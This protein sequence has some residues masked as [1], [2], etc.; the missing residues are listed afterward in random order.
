[1]NIKKNFFVT[2]ATAFLGFAALTVPVTFA[3]ADTLTV[4]PS[5][6]GT[7]DLIGATNAQWTFT[8]TT[9]GA[10]SRGNVIQFTLP[11]VVQAQPFG[12]GTPLLIATT[13][14]SLYPSAIPT[15][16]IPGVSVA[17]TPGGP[18]IYGFATSTVPA[19]TTF[20]VTLGGI[21]GATGQLS[22]M[23]NLAWNV[24][25]GTTA[26]PT[27]P[28]G[29]LSQTAFIATSTK[30]LIRAGGAL[31]SDVNSRITATS[32]NVSA[33]NVSYTFSIK[34]TTT[35]PI[36]GKIMVNF[37][38]TYDLSGATTTSTQTV[39]TSGAQVAM[40]AIATSTGTGTNRVILTTSAAAVTAGN[41]ITV[42]VNGLTNPATAGV[43][44][45]F[46]IF[47]AKAN[48]GL[49]D[50]SYF[51]FE[52][53]DYGSGAPPPSDTV[54][55]GG[56]NT[57]VVQV[58]KANGSGGTTAL[59]AGDIAQ[60]KVGVGCPD[61]GYFMGTQWLNSSGVATY[62][63]I[64]D[65]NYMTGVDPFSK[66]DSSFYSTFLPPGM[67]MVNVVSSGGVGQTSTT[68]LVFGVPN[69]TTT[70]VLT[71]GVSGKNAFINAYSADNQSFANVYQTTGYSTLGFDGSGNGYAQIPINS[72]E[73][74]N[75]SVVGGTFGSGA[76]FTSGGIE[77]WAP[78]IPSIRLTGASTTPVNL[79]S[80]AY[81]SASNTLNVSLVDTSSAPITNAC[82]GVS[83]SGGGV[84]MNQQ[85]VVCSPN[86]GN[87]YQF[88]VPS[89]TI[90]INV[91]RNGF[92]V[93]AQYPVAISSA[94]TNKTITLAAPTSFIN[95]T[96]QTS[97]GTAIN[98]APVFANGSS[99]FGNAMTGSSGTTKIYVQPGTYSVQGFAP[100]F[101]QLTA[102][103]VTVTNSSN[104]SA[105][106]TVNTGTLKTISGTVTQG[107][108]GVAGINVGAHGTGT[109]SGGNNTQTDASGNYTLYV[110]TGTYQ[111]EGWSQGV[112]GLSPQA[113]DVTSGNAANVNWSLGAQG[114]L[115][116]TI[117]NASTISPL[118][119]G[120]SD[121][122]TGKGNGTNTWTTSGTSE[123]A[124]VALPA[125]TYNVQ[126]GSPSLGQF[127]SQIGVAITG[128][129]TTNV[130][131]NAQASSTLVTLSGTTGVA[132]TNVWASRTNGQGFFSTQT[133]ASGNYTLHV[134]DATT[135]RVGVR[136]LAYIATQGDIGVTVS[137]NTT[138]N[139]TL[140]AAG[141]TITGKVFDSNGNGIASGWVT[142]IKTGAASST[143]IGAPTDAG[144]NYT[145]NVDSG[146]VW[147]VTAQGPCYLP[148]SAVAA[149]A[150]DTGKNITLVAQGGCSA[151]TPDVSAITD[152][153]GGQISKSDMTLNIPASALGTSQNSVNVSVTS[154]ATVVS[155]ANATPLAGSVK[156]ITA[157]NSSGQSITS[158]NNDASLSITYDPSQL[159]VGFTE[160]KLQLGYFDNTTGQWE[161]VA[162]TIDTTNHVL[163]AQVS[164]FTE[165]GPILPG[166]PSAPTGLSASAASASQINLSWT[167][168]P[169]ATSYTIYRS[170]TNSGF[171]NSIATGVT[172]ASYSDAGL[173]AST[174]YYYEVAG[175]NSSGEG[176][177]SSAANATTN[178][179]PAVA[180]S[181]GG[182]GPP[183]GFLSTPFLPTAIVSALGKNATSTARSFEIAVASSTPGSIVQTEK[184]SPGVSA[185]FTLTLSFGSR[186]S[187]VLR[188][189]KILGV[190][191]TGYFGHM[192]RRAVEA[193]QIKYGVVSSGAST[194]NG[195]GLFGPKT[196][197][198]IEDIFGVA[199]AGTQP[200][201]AEAHP[202]IQVVFSR[203]LKLGVSGSDVRILQTVLNSDSDTQV[204]I[205][206]DGS[207]GHETGYFGSLTAH[208]V[209]KFQLKHGVVSAGSS[210]L[211]FVGPMTR[212]KL[213]TLRSQ[214]KR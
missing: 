54:Y 28:G 115:H 13:S 181:G 38:S 66:G 134:P 7:D 187:D 202:V 12:V 23:S 177:N 16:T 86:S 108:V 164:H 118:F 179:T 3:F 89:G 30:S 98:G 189:Q 110:P 55:I 11:S 21:N 127:G 213:E 71:G 57:L 185:Y 6:A 135:Y 75:F 92:G 199:A 60:V 155:S 109:T 192:T 37:P 140:T 136:S 81:V 39:S 122:S 83:R 144:G 72:G 191:Q 94:T 208:A 104:P 157:T 130:T 96:V 178:A 204:A 186:G 91:N 24:K 35:V 90:I 214:N 132:N 171:T 88:K 146:S 49:I 149:T 87:N 80:F 70:L 116:I 14:I 193:F 107:G 170:L 198:R 174:P 152:S 106:F 29:S 131:F 123:V 62:N 207:P 119:A 19:G 56:K 210:A 69:A 168:S 68:T 183:V 40:G 124:D 201:S 105:T 20:S 10:I 1:M 44:R 143:Q 111:A 137:G 188:L 166:V 200:F 103:T 154:A 128:G 9:T 112:G 142:A 211:G 95:V 42:T 59:T 77:Y 139:F 147:S 17:N 212:A 195:L 65:C 22:S 84:F 48:N 2:V 100:A 99:G 182:N 162:A 46:S 113:V 190:E 180:S 32:Y 51:G 27:Q 133:D 121:A 4:L 5:S 64:L 61:K 18:V 67:K 169:T 205:S 101:G 114:T 165:Y 125:G 150:G 151:P 161:P 78:V 159:P 163:T 76:N 197:A 117:Q 73:D 184:M 102:Q 167:A 93:P 156:G 47:T 53:S 138:Q 15:T 175:V 145:L 129:G 196:R 43:Y 153:S 58:L 176:P 63:N 97:G 45:P 158:L 74:W 52:Q 173:S 33:T 25:A 34:T 85:D 194:S 172:S 79:G 126:A 50:G 36:G 26:D 31:V 8:A 41:V 206:G 82:V 203:N 209:G 148:S 141:A 120:A 160:S